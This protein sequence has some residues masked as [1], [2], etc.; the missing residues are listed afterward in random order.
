MKVYLINNVDLI[1][2]MKRLIKLKA[3]LGV[4]AWS[5]D[6]SDCKF[7][8]Q[9]LIDATDEKLETIK[10][11]SKV[12]KVLS[13]DEDMAYFEYINSNVIVMK[14]LD[15]G[16]IDSDVKKALGEK[17]PPLLKNEIKEV[18]DLSFILIA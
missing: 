2:K 1:P 7:D 6:F 11:N 14:L 8:I 17:I 5:N 3:N 16:I 13:H 12:L 15:T 18:S 9:E 10:N 4:C